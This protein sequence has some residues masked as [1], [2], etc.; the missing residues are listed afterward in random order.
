L[1]EHLLK[2]ARGL[3]LSFASVFATLVGLAT[4]T[5]LRA[6]AWTWAQLGVALFAALVAAMLALALPKRRRV[7]RVAAVVV[8]VSLGR[9][10]WAAFPRRGAEHPGAL[11][12]T[13]FVASP[14]DTRLFWQGL[15]ERQT[16][17]LGG[18][19]VACICRMHSIRICRSCMRPSVSC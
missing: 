7:R 17:T 18:A 9:T 16:V 14:P 12:R 13:R 1:R 3:T 15:P 6:H 2:A 8:I 5:S 10:G 19:S 11:V 4:I